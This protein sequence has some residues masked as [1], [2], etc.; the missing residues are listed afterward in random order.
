MKYIIVDLEATCWENKDLQ[1]KNEI[2]EIG[3]VC[4]NTEGEIQ[5]EFSEFV[6]P[7]INPV[8][9]EFCKKLTTIKQNDIDAAESFK[10]VIERFKNWINVNEDYMLCSWGF[11]DKSQFKSDCELHKLG[12]NWLNHHISLK[13]QYAEIKKLQRPIG[14][15]GALKIEKLQIDGTHH[16]GI[17]DAR[18]IAK[19]FIQHIDKWKYK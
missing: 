4:I 5:S 18:N 8:L 2:I 7:L 15:A 13:H 14:M 16:R 17:D 1:K 11:Y 9:S 10:E 3:A 6:K 12:T 19:I